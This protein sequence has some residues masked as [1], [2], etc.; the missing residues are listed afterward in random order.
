MIGTPEGAAK[1]R[2]APVRQ[3]QK[4]RTR[5][6]KVKQML[7]RSAEKH[8]P[9][10]NTRKKQDKYAQICVHVYLM[11]VIPPAELGG[12]LHVYEV[13]SKKASRVRNSSLRS[14]ILGQCRGS[15]IGQRFSAGKV[16]M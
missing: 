12:R 6:D 14:E 16:L 2:R 4:A 7:T 10:K 8:R 5:K 11:E 13:R 1:N 3:K 15:E 9:T